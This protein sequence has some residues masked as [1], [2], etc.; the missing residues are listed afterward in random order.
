MKHS[1]TLILSGLLLAALIIGCATDEPSTPG[2]MD[3]ATGSGTTTGGTDPSFDSTISAW[4]GQT[5][6]DASSA[7]NVGTDK[8]IYHE[9]NTF[10]NV[11]TITYNGTSASYTSTNDNIIVYHTGAHVTVD[12][13]TND[14]DK[15]E[16]ILRGASSDGSLKVYGASK[17]KL[18]LDGVSL[19]SSRGPA[20]NSQCK[21]RVYIALA[22]G[23]S[24]S[25]TDASAYDSDY[26]YLNGGT[27]D[28]EDRKGC[29]FAEGNIIFSGAGTLQV[30]G[31][32]KHGVCTD[33]YMVL[34]PGVT[35]V[36]NEAAKN[37]IHVKGD[38]DDNMG[39]QV[40]GGLI[41]TYTSATA[42]KGIK[43][44]R[45]VDIQGG[46]LLLNVSGG[47]E[48]DKDEADTSSAA[49]IKTDTYVSISGGTHVLKAT[50]TAGKGINADGYFTMSGGTVTVTTTGGKFTYNRNFTS[51]PKGVK[52]DGNVTISGGTLNVQVTGASDSSEGLES[53]AAMTI[54]GG[55]VYVW[56]Y[57]DAIN[58]SSAFT[59]TGGSVLAYSSTCDGIDSNGSLT[60]SGG[61]VIGV[62]GSSPEGGID[63]DSSSKFLVNGGTMISLGGTLQT[64]P[65]SSSKQRTV[66]AN[67]VTASKGAVM[68]ALDSSG[69]SLL[70]YTLPRS[71][72][73]GNFTFSVPGLTS[74]VTYTLQCDD[75]TLATFTC[76]SMITTIGSSSG[77]MGGNPGGWR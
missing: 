52:A 1:L 35:L 5:A 47:A 74:G 39:I 46:Q 21:K 20:I 37:C 62:G 28:T 14:V 60:I 34:R 76:S 6:T 11:L 50:G 23:S 38:E 65:S 15:T 61:K 72:S 71:L 68:Q 13:L 4:D 32:M 16:I 41:Y 53:K 49:A 69:N 54:S 7:S 29:L 3:G 75:T 8:D 18:T 12:M 73:S 58:A 43:C 26:Q 77:G 57:E 17:H 19:T 40:L 42:G 55:D 66:V 70:S 9:L 67:G 48:Y 36:V 25:L 51:S 44:D 63:C 30:N 45:Q 56:A 59:V 33:G 22:D 2:N 24:N 10:S 27:V 64:T 31:K